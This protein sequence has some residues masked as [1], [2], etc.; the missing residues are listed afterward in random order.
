VGFGMGGAYV[1]PTLWEPPTETASQ[2]LIE[3]TFAHKKCKAY[4]A[5]DCL[6]NRLAGTRLCC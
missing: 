5:G 4:K 1:W 2:R 6:N 3:L